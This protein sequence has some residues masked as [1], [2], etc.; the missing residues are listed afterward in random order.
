LEFRLPE[1]DDFVEWRFKQIEAVWA[2]PALTDEARGH[3]LQAAKMAWQ[4]EKGYGLCDGT[5]SFG[6]CERCRVEAEFIDAL[7]TQV[8]ERDGRAA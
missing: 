4:C 2:C 3:L 1:A 6:G 5:G 8:T 7:A